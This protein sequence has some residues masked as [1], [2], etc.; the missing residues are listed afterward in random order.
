MAAGILVSSVSAATCVDAHVKSAEDT[1]KNIESERY[2][3]YGGEL[4]EKRVDSWLRNNSFN[5]SFKISDA[6]FFLSIIRND[7]G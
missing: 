6:F 7:I 2:P 4:F 1:K 3:E 5:A